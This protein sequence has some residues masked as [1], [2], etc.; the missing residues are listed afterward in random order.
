MTI[1]TETETVIKKILPYLRRRGYE[2][3]KDLDFETAVKIPDRYH[4]G[5]IDILVT[6]GGA[7]PK[8]VI[9]AKKSSKVLTDKDRA[10]AVGYGV[11]LKVPFVVVT[12]GT[13]IQ[14][15]NTN[16]KTSLQWNGRLE[17][18]IP[19][20]AQ[21][22]SVLKALRTD[23][24]ATNIPLSMDGSTDA[25]LPFH[26]GL[27]LKQLNAMFARCHNAIRKI[28]KN[29]EFAFADFSKLLFLKLLEEKQDDGD[30]A[31]PYSYR[32]DELAETPNHRSDQIRDSVQK[33][34]AQIRNDTAFGDVLDDE[35]HLKKPETFRYII[36]QL[37]SISFRDSTSD[38]K[39]AA[40]EY[41]VRATLK[42][43]RLGQY[44]T[45]R[46]LVELMVA[47]IGGEKIANAAISTTSIRV[48]DPACGTGGFLVYAMRH[49]IEILRKRLEGSVISQ[50]VFE[51]G[52]K[53]L[54]RQIFFGSEASEGVACAAKMNMIVAGDGHTNIIPE[55]S[56]RVDSRNWHMD[57][58]TCDVILTNPPFGTSETDS[59][60]SD[61]QAAYPIRS[62]KGQHLFLQH[63]VLS[64]VP[65]GD[66]CTV[67]DDGV[68][69]T[70]SAGGLRE[71]L[72]EQ[73]RLVA[74]LSLPDE[75]FKPNKINVKSS[76]L[77]LRRREDPDVNHDSDHSVIFCDVDSL[78]YEGSGEPIRGF[79]FP[80]LI[81]SISAC[82]RGSAGARSGFGWSAFDVRMSS[83]WKDPSKRLDLKYWRPD[84]R[85]RIAALRD[86]GAPTIKDLAGQPVKRGK[87]PSA[88][89]YV[90]R[91]DGFAL[92]IKS[93]TNISKLGALLDEG[94]DLDY[95]EKNIYD[96]M[97]DAHVEDGDVL[98]SSTGDGTLGKCCV[99]R[100]KEPAIA[101]G[102]VTIIRADRTR[103]VPE[104]LCDYLRAGLGAREF[105]RLFSGST[106]MIELTPEH[107]NSILVDIL[108]GDL[109][110]QEA[111]SNALRAGERAATLKQ[112]EADSDLRAA[113]L[114]FIAGRRTAP[115]V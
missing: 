13:T 45:P 50:R 52:R 101:D 44:F 67:I 55:D 10:Q 16:T 66:I 1:R 95:V 31:L 100:T 79:D 41:F 80:A 6:C 32:F 30:I 115:E 27:P 73:C 70:D 11:A 109:K 114:A 72:L 113:R 20:K 47:L 91:R 7:A 64:A 87:S 86:S 69:N 108:D 111:A 90:D 48:M 98:L 28:E 65:G 102:H 25:G 99:C 85:E 68:L 74:V 8:F 82:I 105:E 26:P 22:P 39:G 106:G 3:E 88:E 4:K 92:V 89:L 60:P 34:I 77:Y 23:K 63:M 46:P 59:L 21:L 49:G 14:C 2:P 83:I 76:V 12:N 53:R 104:Y 18:Y 19:S 5:Y 93:G 58:A 61:D 40:F 71:W 37:A 110:S 9:E 56:L 29:E 96:E 38:S 54:M 35:I 42:G 107:V 36:Q 57:Q 97:P 62:T 81:G 75:T 15:L 17:G 112:K 103:I 51:D 33:M 43:K 94:D 78:G 24:L 84:Q